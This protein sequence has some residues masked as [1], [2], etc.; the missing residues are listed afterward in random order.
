MIYNRADFDKE[1]Q[2]I[3]K[4]LEDMRRDC[5]ELRK[6]AAVR[7]YLIKELI[8]KHEELIAI[9]DGT[10]ESKQYTKEWWE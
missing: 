6:K 9:I 4:G 1:A 2:D 3:K 8:S 7:E 5:D 10:A